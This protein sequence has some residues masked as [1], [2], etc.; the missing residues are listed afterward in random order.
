MAILDQKWSTLPVP[1]AMTVPDP[2][3]EERSF[4]PDFGV[5]YETLRPA[6]HSINVNPLER[7]IVD[8]GF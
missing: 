5:R 3:P 8:L 4:D 2:V 7:P 1:R 6:L